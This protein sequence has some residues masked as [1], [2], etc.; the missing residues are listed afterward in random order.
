MGKIEKI[1]SNLKYRVAR[2]FILYILLVSSIITGVGT[3][4]QLYMDYSR[5]VKSIHNTFQQIDVSYVPIITNIL[6]ASNIDMLEVQL[7]GILKLRDMQYIEVELEDK[8]RIRMGTSSTRNVITHN[9]VLSYN[10]QDREVYLGTMR[11][12]ANL[13]GVYKRLL[14]KVFIILFIQ[15]FKT[16]I[17]SFFIFFIFYILVSR[18]LHNIAG[19]I[20]SISLDRLDN[21][22]RLEGYSEKYDE[23]D[24]FAVLTKSFNDM[25]INL[26]NEIKMR[27]QAETFLKESENRYRSLITEMSAGFALLE[28]LCNENSTPYN[29]RFLQVNAALERMAGIERKKI[30]GQTILD[31]IPGLEKYWVNKL[32]EVALT[33]NPKAFE[34]YS[35]GLGRHFYVIAYSPQKGQFATIVEDISKRK[36]VEEELEEH[37]KHL[38]GMVDERTAAL[39]DAQKKL[40]SAERLAT[41]GQLSGSISHELRNPLAV[42]D[43]SVYYLRNKIPNP[44]KKVME[45]LNRIIGQVKHSTAI[46]ESLL[47]LTRIKSPRKDKLDLTNLIDKVIS[48][49]DIPK[50]I[51]IFKEMKEVAMVLGDSEQ[52]YMIFENIIKNAVD[53]MNKK[54]T[55]TIRIDFSND[56]RFVEVMI[57]DTGSGIQ[58]EY[59][60]EIF[61]PLFSTKARG[62]GFGLSICQQIVEKHGGSIAVISEPEKGACFTVKL[63]IMEG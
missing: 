3:G 9:H 61:K 55:L 7:Q 16:F 56:V 33:G 51:N 15:A 18:H 49:S 59:I 22:L 27:D 43:S 25:R 37:R 38:E 63:P 47:N 12:K 19:Y 1:L 30:I 5:D 10:F 42:I 52:L 54:G 45:H 6:W 2:K 31:I 48:E 40:L 17:V 34:G 4:I 41:L 20:K 39:R 23:K 53:A 13:G 62:I 36:K 29:F 21:P 32:G 57:K 24:E 46:I 58:P 60:T 14:D 8:R 35:K 28:V 11:I 50:T 26:I 44:D